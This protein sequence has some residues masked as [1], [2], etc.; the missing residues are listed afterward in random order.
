MN[1]KNLSASSIF[2]R[3]ASFL[4]NIFAISLILA[5]CTLIGQTSAQAATAK[6]GGSCTTLGKTTQISGKNYICSPTGVNSKKYIW[7]LAKITG[8]PSISGSS[9][10][11]GG[12]GNGGPGDGGP[13]D[14]GPGDGDHH[15]DGFNSN[16]PAFAVFNKC[17][18]AAGITPPK[19]NATGTRP[20]LTAAQRVAMDKCR[21]SSGINFGGPD[22]HNGSDH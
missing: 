13:G 16:N 6:A 8:R 5:S 12:Q 19:R 3:N 22:D 10:S 21:A 15:F 17:L 7:T 1:K 18:T 11:A 9:G 20:Q 2:L 4:R 14:G